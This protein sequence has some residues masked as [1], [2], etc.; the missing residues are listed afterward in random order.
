VTNSIIAGSSIIGATFEADL[1]RTDAL[2]VNGIPIIGEEQIDLLITSPDIKTYPV[3]LKAKFPLTIVDM[4]HRLDAG[5]V[6]VDLEIEGVPVGGIEDISVTVAEGT[7]VATSANDLSL[8]EEL[9][10]SVTGA[11]AGTDNLA[12]SIKMARV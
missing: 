12:I 6:T 5:A 8:G 1:V 11:T 4:T 10:L 2:E 3:R 7:E 9:S